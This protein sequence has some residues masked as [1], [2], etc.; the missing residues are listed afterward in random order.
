MDELSQRL[1]DVTIAIGGSNEA[2]RD[3]STKDIATQTGVSE[4]TLFSRFPSKDSLVDA[5]S[6]ECTIRFAA[7]A[8]KLID[9]GLT[10]KKWVCKMIDHQ[11]EKKEESIFLLNYAHAID[12]GPNPQEAEINY[13]KLILNIGSQIMCNYRFKCEEDLFICSS[14]IIRTILY[15]VAYILNGVWPNNDD[16]RENICH[17]IRGGINSF[18]KDQRS[19]L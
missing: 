7:Y 14:S 9:D 2:N 10:G 5:A 19:P 15:A 17:I 13:Y 11:L 18:L 16:V 1:I 12:H 4:P 6:E 3:F 8:K